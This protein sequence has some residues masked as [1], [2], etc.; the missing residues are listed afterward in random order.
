MG[1]GLVHTGSGGWKLASVYVWALYEKDLGFN[2]TGFGML[3]NQ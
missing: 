1:G 2:K 3:K